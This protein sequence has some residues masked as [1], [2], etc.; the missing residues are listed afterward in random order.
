MD[1]H[2][3]FTASEIADLCAK[4]YFVTVTNETSRYRRRTRKYKRY[5]ER[6]F[7]KYAWPLYEYYKGLAFDK[8][9]DLAILDGEK[10]VCENVDLILQD[11]KSLYWFCRRT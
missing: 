2:L 9:K 6:Y 8:Y 11:L 4:K 7:D 5:D 3:I 1:G 10:Q